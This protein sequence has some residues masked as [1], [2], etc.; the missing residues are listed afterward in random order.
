[1]TFTW[2]RGPLH[3]I[4]V[5]PSASSSVGNCIFS[6]TLFSSGGTGDCQ[7]RSIGGREPWRGWGYEEE[8]EEGIERVGKKGGEGGEREE[9][10]EERKVG[11]ERT[12][13]SNSVPDKLT[14]L[15]IFSS[16]GLR[17]SKSWSA[18]TW[19]TTIRARLSGR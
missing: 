14:L 13:Y 3:A 4:L 7:G 11:I 10:R 17:A 6:Y 9:R 16:R 1:M 18:S 19:P 15:I 12:L 5:I 2:A 8:R